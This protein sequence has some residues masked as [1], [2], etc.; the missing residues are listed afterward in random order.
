MERLLIN[1]ANYFKQDTIEAIRKEF[2]F[3]QSIH[4]EMLLWDFEIFAQLTAIH[5]DFVLKGGAAA[6]IYL[7]VEKQRASRD[8]DLATTLGEKEIESDD[9][10]EEKEQKIAI[11]LKELNY[12]DSA[13]LNVFIY[14]RANLEKLGGRFCLLE[15]N[16][17]IMDVLAVVGL[18]DIFTILHDKDKL[19]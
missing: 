6:Q 7:P 3:S 2:K 5:K 19:H 17:Y 16:A 1:N 12:I 9:S 13:A 11:H 15:P 8:I 10:E 18:T 4:I 14:A